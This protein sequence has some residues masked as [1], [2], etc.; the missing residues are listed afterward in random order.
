MNSVATD[1]VK[2]AQAAIRTVLQL[3]KERAAL[4][5][6]RKELDERIV[7]ALMEAVEDVIPGRSDYVEV[8]GVT[9]RCWSEGGKPR[10][11]PI[12]IKGR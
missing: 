5:E 3:T 2:Q 8:D 4:E 10:I 6:Q 1:N 11:E 7:N 9:Y 12:T